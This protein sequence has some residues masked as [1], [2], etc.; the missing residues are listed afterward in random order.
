ME[1]NPAESPDPKG[2]VPHLSF[3]DA[4]H[5]YPKHRWFTGTAW[6]YT[7]VEG[8]FGIAR[9]HELWASSA[10]MLNDAGEMSYGVARV[11]D[12]GSR[13]SAPAGSDPAASELLQRAIENLEDSMIENAPFVL[14][15]STSPFLLNQWANYGDSSGCAVGLDALSLL[16]DAD[17]SG[18]PSPR[19]ALPLWLEVVYEREDQDAYI[20][21]L[22]DELV[23]QDKLISQAIRHDHEPAS[24]LEQNLS[25]LVAALKHPAF[26]AESEV[27]VVVMKQESTTTHYR[28][29]ARGIV[30]FV[31]L[32]GTISDPEKGLQAAIAGT[33]PLPLPITA[34]HVGPPQG[35]SERRRVAS[36]REFLRSRG[37]DVEVDGAGIPYLP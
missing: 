24:L 7:S 3:G 13:W 15:A 11:Q 12:V 29:T 17:R 34:V 23:S 5:E 35:D 37:Y 30:P 4:W 20:R 26:R 1:V 18:G 22:L 8:C 19:Q 33:S 2:V 27:R 21:E 10:A 28:P 6:H 16:H 36:M 31:K 25:M 9:N 32:H 14:S